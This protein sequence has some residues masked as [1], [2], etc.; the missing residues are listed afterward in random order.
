MTNEQ[1]HHSDQI[2]AQ[3]QPRQAVGKHREARRAFFEC[4]LANRFTLLKLHKVNERGECSCNSWS[5]TRGRSIQERWQAHK[6]GRVL[7]CKQPG[8]HMTAP[9]QRCKMKTV[10][11]VEA[12]MDAGGSVGLC[13]RIEEA[14]SPLRMVIYDC[15]RPGAAEWL[16]ARGIQS[17]IEVYGR[18]EGS[19]HIYALLA[20]D[21]PELKTDTRSLNPHT[22][23][24]TT[25]EKPGVDIKTSGLVVLPFS[26]NKRLVINGQDVSDDPY[27]IR[28]AFGSLD[29][30][31]KFLPVSDPRVLAPKMTMHTVGEARGFIYDVREV[32]G[33]A[34][35]VCDTDTRS[36]RDKEPLSTARPR[37]EQLVG[38]YR[39][40]PY[41]QRKHWARKFA[42][43]DAH[44]AIEGQN[45]DST[46]FG[47]A[48]V[49]RRRFEIS[50]EDMFQLLKHHYSPRCRDAQGKLYPYGD[51]QIVH[52]IEGTR[53]SQWIDPLMNG[54]EPG[55]SP[56]NHNEEM[57]T[58]MK[59]RLKV[60]DARSNTRRMR[61]AY[62]ERETRINLVQ[63]FLQ[64][65]YVLH[66]SNQRTP[67]K[68]LLDALNQWIGD[69]HAG[70]TFNVNQLARALTALGI[71]H[72]R[73][74]VLG[75]MMVLE[76]AA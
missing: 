56:P 31:K 30:M 23:N 45:P 73:G 26:P 50:E 59:E 46:L 12:H 6:E 71:E 52:V 21:C 47:V 61:R 54:V 13:L 49:L 16:A 39:E 44:P 32:E 19:K 9:F 53:D 55:M 24:P 60:R 48:I 8:K 67:I 75:L 5:S 65:R 1:P 37:K 18:R 74:K 72:R 62:I 64:A 66:A 42:R 27:A 35:S 3:E 38:V 17:V 34:T 28:A 2:P 41:H 57:I 29:A 4:L 22:G 7:P 40:F 58:C 63:R 70:P 43:L 11:A 33:G 14:R 36:P 69:N 51:R 15:D 20:D 10:E 68:E 76:A 25:D